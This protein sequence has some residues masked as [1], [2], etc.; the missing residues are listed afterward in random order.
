MNAN[1]LADLTRQPAFASPFKLAAL[2]AEIKVNRGKYSSEIETV[3]VK[4]GENQNMVYFTDM[5]S[6]VE[7]QRS[8]RR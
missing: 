5:G 3:I 8:V 2:G 6:C 7:A 1:D 4:L